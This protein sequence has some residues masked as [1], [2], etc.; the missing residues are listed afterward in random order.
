MAYL[1]STPDRNSGRPSSRCGL[2][3]LDRPL[4]IDKQLALRAHVFC[5]LLRKVSSEA[6]L[7]HFDGGNFRRVLHV[8]AHV[9]NPWRFR[10]QS[11]LV[12][13][14]F[15]GL[16]MRRSLSQSGFTTV[17]TRVKRGA[18]GKG[19]KETFEK[20]LAAVKRGTFP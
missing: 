17:G 19:F 6:A 3:Q 20:N 18:G 7:V 1:N 9:R 15:D 2:T 8:L 11:A 5:C 4:S 10:K 13:L 16:R 14:C 12:G